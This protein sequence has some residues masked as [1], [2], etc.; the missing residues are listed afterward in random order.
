MLLSVH[1][2]KT[3]CESILR[4][5]FAGTGKRKNRTKEI[6]NDKSWIS[7]FTLF[8]LLLRFDCR[9]SFYLYKGLSLRFF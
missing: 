3:I 5:F 9:F 4:S 7:G 2:N 8:L 1:A 6:Q